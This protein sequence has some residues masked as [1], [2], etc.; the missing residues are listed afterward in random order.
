MNALARSVSACLA[1][2]LLAAL[3]ARPA[4]AEPP[5]VFVLPVH[6]HGW[7]DH[8]DRLLEARVALALT[9]GHRIR[10]VGERDLAA[11][12]RRQLPMEL[13]E[14]TAPAC[15][16]ALGQSSG[17]ARVLALELFE[18]GERA[19]LLAT[20]FDPRTGEAVDRREL[21]RA[22]ARAPS[23]AWADEVARW[24]ATSSAGFHPP[25]TPFPP[26][27][28]T[29]VLV[30]L[31]LDPEQLARPEGQA[32][33]AQLRDQLTRRG[34]PRLTPPGADG[35]VTHRAVISVEGF[36]IS[37]RPHHVHR[38]RSGALAADLTV[39]EVRTGAVVFSKRA[40]GEL[41]TRAHHTTDQQTLSLLVDDVVFRWMA[42]IEA[43]SLDQTLSRGL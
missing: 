26:P 3:A 15:L 9:R 4:R 36:G 5:R 42:E 33:L 31:G 39:T 17:A 8:D 34:H 22:E 28:P 24:V 11:G 29:A 16:R 41:T 19:V 38:Y 23:R 18:E 12:A 1:C 13:D 10:P 37:E 40:V 7:L 32:L 6:S 30:S 27:R 25:P 14:C 20:L 35:P 43:A 2:L 21:P